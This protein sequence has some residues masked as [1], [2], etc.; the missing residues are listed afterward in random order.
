MEKSRRSKKIAETFEALAKVRLRYNAG[1]VRAATNRPIQPIQ[2]A[3]NI[4]AA[5]N[6]HIQ[7]AY[8]CTR[9]VCN[10]FAL[11]F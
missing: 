9:F 7:D 2:D 5:T 11:V 6:R 4:Q 3:A 10:V 1:T 8:H